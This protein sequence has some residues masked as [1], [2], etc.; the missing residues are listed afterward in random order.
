MPP[1]L[2][3]TPQDE[4]RTNS[5]QAVCSI[6]KSHVNLTIFMDH[7]DCCSAKMLEDNEN[8]RFMGDVCNSTTNHCYDKVSSL[9]EMFPYITKERIKDLV[10]RNTSIKR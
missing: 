10:K 8:E 7:L 6:C 9:L 5:A 1:S 2:F 4:N 3:E